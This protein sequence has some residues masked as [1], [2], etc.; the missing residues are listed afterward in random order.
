MTIRSSQK[1]KARPERTQAFAWPLCCCMLVVWVFLPEKETRA[2]RL[3]RHL[4]LLGRRPR[5]LHGNVQNG[6]LPG[7]FAQR[8]GALA[9]T[10]SAEVCLGF[11]R[12]QTGLISGNEQVGIP[13][14]SNSFTAYR[15]S[16]FLERLCPSVEQ[17]IFRGF[18][19][20]GACARA[21]GVSCERP[22]VAVLA[23]GSAGGS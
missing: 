5:R 4:L 7:H 15:T 9:E 6:A 8:Q 23:G 10:V 19:K 13:L 3:L 2:E 11:R 22:T 1:R 21:A 16:K 17:Y 20:F 18:W 12:G 14:N